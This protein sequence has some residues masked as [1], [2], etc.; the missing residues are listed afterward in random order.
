MSVTSKI[1]NSAQQGRVR[2]ND[3]DKDI[4]SNNLLIF[5]RII[6]VNILYGIVSINTTVEQPIPAQKTKPQHNIYET[7]NM[8]VIQ[9]V[10]SKKAISNQI[11]SNQIS[12]LKSLHS[13]YIMFIFINPTGVF[14]L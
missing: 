10:Y 4:T 14:N 8:V 12:F 1:P 11:K 2:I 7:E 9:R 5:S 6:C 3:D 13:I